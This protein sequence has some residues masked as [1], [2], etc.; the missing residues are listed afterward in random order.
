MSISNLECKQSLV[1]D[2]QQ[3]SLQ[4][5]IQGAQKISLIQSEGLIYPA[6]SDD[7][8][9]IEEEPKST[10]F[11]ATAQIL[12]SGIGSGVLFLPS[13]FQACGITLSSIFMVL[14]AIVCYFCWSLVSQIIRFQESTDTK[15]PTNRHL[16]L[17]EAG[18]KL[19]GKGF[20]IFIQVCTYIYS[21][22]TCFG[23]AIFIYQ[24]TEDTIPNHMVTMAIM[25]A[26]YLPF[27][28]YKKIDRLYLLTYIALAANI[29]TLV[30]IVGK[31][32]Y[33]IGT[34]NVNFPQLTQFNFSQLPLQF[35]VFSFAY[36]ING[37]YTEIHASMKNKNQFDK[38]LQ[39]YLTI[40]TIMGILVGLLGYVA[41]G[42]NTEAVIFNNIGSMNGVGTA[43]AFLYSLAEL[44]S[45]LLYVFCVV[46]FFDKTINKYILKD[47]TKCMT[48]FQEFMVRSILFFSFAFLGLYVTQINAV[49]NIMGCVFCTILTY[50]CPIFL[51]YKARKNQDIILNSNQV[52]DSEKG[53][54]SEKPNIILLNKSNWIYVLSGFCLVFGLLGGISGLVSSIISLEESGF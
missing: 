51:Y 20:K 3:L 8:I 40:F 37:V 26:I 36:D 35:G 6:S 7:D 28:M 11:V 41:F 25:Y 15:D 30:F 4:P 32:S 27:S 47:A 43:L 1:E 44:A 18:G 13:T 34:T 12:K 46:K 5:L 17:D 48:F 2:D 22:S 9:K 45:I 10:V 24:S 33:I 54:S 53:E 50:A 31:S 14:C 19:F 49:F 52:Q 23:Y 21:Y 38:V 39:Y 42:E 16:T 29:I